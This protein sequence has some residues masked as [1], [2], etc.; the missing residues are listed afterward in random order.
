MQAFKWIKYTKYYYVIISR[1]YVIHF[2]VPKE[3]FKLLLSFPPRISKFLLPQTFFYID[4]ILSKIS[5]LLP[6]HTGFLGT[7]V[8]MPLFNFLGTVISYLSSY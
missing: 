5:L 8:P 4:Q 6:I 1:L 7:R 3:C 2:Y